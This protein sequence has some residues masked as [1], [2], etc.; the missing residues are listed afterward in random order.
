MQKEEQEGGGEPQYAQSDEQ[1]D[2]S[3]TCHFTQILDN[4]GPPLAP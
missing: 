1:L 4:Q 3:G 2:H